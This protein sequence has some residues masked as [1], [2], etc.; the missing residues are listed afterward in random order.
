MNWR[1]LAT[2]PSFQVVAHF[3]L[4]GR[5]LYFVSE[6]VVFSPREHS[7]DPT[8]KIA[9]RGFLAILSSYHFSFLLF[10]TFYLNAYNYGN[11]AQL[12]AKIS[13]GSPDSKTST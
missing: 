6:N 4:L 11:L 5:R 12:R 10:R 8:L 9:G 7:R 3:S 13:L 2:P 1:S